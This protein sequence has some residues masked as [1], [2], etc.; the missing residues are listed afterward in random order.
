MYSGFIYKI[1]FPN[2][3]H[4]IGLTTTSLETRKQQHKSCAKNDT[5]CVYNALRK[6]DMVDNFEL[7]EIDTAY[8]IGELCEKEIEYI[9][10]YNSHYIDGYGYNMT[11]GGEGVNGYVFTKEDKLK[12]SEAQK[13]F[14]EDN[15]HIKKQISEAL[16]RYYE[17]NPEAKLKMSAVKKKWYEEHPEAGTAQSERHKKWYEENPEARTAQS[18][19][20]KKRFEENPELI[21]QMSER[22]KKYYEEN[23]EAREKMSE[24][25]KKWHE[26][27]PEARMEQGIKLTQHYK[28][29]PE[30]IQRISDGVKKYFEDPESRKR[31]SISQKKRFENPEAREQCSESQK[32]RFENPEAKKQMSAVKKK[33]YEDNPEVKQQISENKKKW[34]EEHPEAKYIKLDTQGANKPFDLFTID[35]TFV[36][37]FT[38]QIDAREYLQ[39]EYNITSYIKIGRVLSGKRKSCAGFIFKYKENLV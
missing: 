29:N 31:S 33:Y 39:K 25:K 32:K 20:M 9:Q 2:G 3:K 18:E 36:K 10:I 17:N 5:K 14:Y 4:Y 6:Y 11:Y 15:P 16:K 27:H 21:Q 1:S 13:K 12:M 22:G 28:E 8:T 19:R 24:N 38:Y 23:P 35:G 30:T 26:E 37:T 7:V 34:H